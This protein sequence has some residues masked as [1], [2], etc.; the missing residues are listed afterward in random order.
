[1]GTIGSANKIVGQL[2]DGFAPMLTTILHEKA[3]EAEV[4]IR[5]QLSSG[6]DGDGRL[7]R[8][9]YLEDP[10]FNSPEAGSWRGGADRYMA[11]KRE[12]TPPYDSSWLG[13]PRRPVDTP[14]LFI[15]G[16]FH[17]SIRAMPV[18]KGVRISSQHCEFAPEL[19]MK[20][21]TNI[22]KMGWW[23]KK[24]FVEQYIRRG[25]EDYFKRFSVK[26]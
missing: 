5:E 25:I 23:S 22:Y 26:K 3:S 13:I 18:D 21:G 6:Q 7:L 14:N 19:E 15:D 24:Y 11:W 20:Y 8:P 12:I 10:W 9:T 4:C 16:T 1:M 17:R 2:C